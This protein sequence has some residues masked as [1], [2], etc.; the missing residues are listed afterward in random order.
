[1]LPNT[2]DSFARNL[3]KG[4]RR[5]FNVQTVTLDGVIVAT[6][7]NGT[8]KQVRNGLFKETYEE[9]ERILI[10]AALHPTDRVLEIGGGIGFVSI[11]C[12]KI[13]P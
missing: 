4:F 5:L 12:A 1:M 8:S 9:P 13:W 11:L 3:R 2:N 6:N 10:R 7:A